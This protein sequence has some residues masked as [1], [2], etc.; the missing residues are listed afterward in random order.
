MHVPAF[1][2]TLRADAIASTGSSELSLQQSS[3]CVR[4]CSCH[5]CCPAQVSSCHSLRNQPRETQRRDG[6]NRLP[7]VPR[8][9]KFIELLNPASE[10]HMG[11]WL[12]NLLTWELC[13]CQAVA[14][15]RPGLSPTCEDLSKTSGGGSRRS[16]RPF[17]TMRQASRVTVFSSKSSRNQAASYLEDVSEWTTLLTAR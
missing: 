4:A 14:A 16:S 1:S 15:G 8:K 11:S 3:V 2:A 13:L 5:N 12:Q 9:T 10:E 6:W 7:I 17:S